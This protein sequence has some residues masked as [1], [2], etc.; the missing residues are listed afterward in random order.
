MGTLICFFITSLQ[1]KMLLLNG[2]FLNNDNQAI[3]LFIR[4]A[5]FQFFS[6]HPNIANTFATA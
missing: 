5:N 1:L 4:A 6:D 3:K 2:L